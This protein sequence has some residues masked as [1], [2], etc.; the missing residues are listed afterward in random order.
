[1]MKKFNDEILEEGK[2]YLWIK[3]NIVPIIFISFTVF[4]FL[5]SPEVP[6]HFFINELASR[7]FRDTFLV[8]SLVIPVVA[9]LG[10]NFGIVIGAIA[11]QIAVIIACYYRFGGV[12]GLLL[13]FIIA[14]PIAALLGYFLGLLYNRAKGKEMIV[15]LITVYI[16]NNLYQFISVNIFGPIIKLDTANP[17]VNE[18]GML[19]S[20]IKLIPAQ[21]GG[22]RNALDNILKIPFMNAV[23]IV[24]FVILLIILLNNKKNYDLSKK[25]IAFYS[26]IAI[27]TI[28]IIISACSIV[29]FNS[30]MRVNRAPVFT[31]LLI[32]SMYVFNELI[33]KTKLG[34]DFKMIGRNQDIVESSIIHVD[35][36]RIIATVISTVSA[37]LG[38]IISLQNME[39]LNTYGV[40]SQIGIFS[41]AALLIGGATTTKAS[42][43]NAILGALLI[44][45]IYIMLPNVGEVVFKNTLL[46][47]SLFLFIIYGVILYSLTRVKEVKNNEKV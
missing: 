11:G 12:S 8:L 35:R 14:L 34:D 43:S 10:L 24:A 5:V 31:A 41:I 44:N 45:S 3:N 37:A 39:S 4:A 40:S 33:M 19:N 18:S 47:S 17:V 22:L 16:V 27:C 42:S 13:C 2:V 6:V 25:N 1:M 46:G 26:K 23:L 36:T 28:I 15:G 30:F 9:G 20:S 29:S 38:Q 32:I 7:F 21:D